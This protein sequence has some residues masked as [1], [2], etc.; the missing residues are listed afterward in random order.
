M[1]SKHLI[2]FPFFRS[3]KSVSSFN[4]AE[5]SSMASSQNLPAVL[6]DPRKGNNLLCNVERLILSGFYLWANRDILKS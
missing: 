1:S 4:A 3:T 6:N 5:I 2:N